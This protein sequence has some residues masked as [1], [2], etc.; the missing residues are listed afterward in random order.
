MAEEGDRDNEVELVKEGEEG[1]GL[2]GQWV[3]E[4]FWDGDMIGL[5]REGGDW[6]QS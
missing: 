5:V 1:F 6:R 3:V 2:V 4:A